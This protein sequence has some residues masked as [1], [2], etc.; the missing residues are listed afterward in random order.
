VPLSS[1]DDY[2]A[3]LDRI[4]AGASNVLTRERVLLLEPT[5]GST[6]GEKLIPYTAGLRHEFQRGVATWI[7][8]LFG[9]RPAVRQG[10]AYWS[11]SP[12]AGSRRRTPGGIPIGFDDDAAYL[13]TVERLAL[14]RLLIVP[15]AVARLADPESFQYCTLFHLLAAGDLALMS[16][17]NPTFLTALLT[18]LHDWAEPAACRVRLSACLLT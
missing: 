2:A 8:D 16:I 15:A 13:G 10:R 18:P 14:D 11:I 6:G 17:W 12:A 1:Y 3:Y 5:S 7:A 9:Q 4:A